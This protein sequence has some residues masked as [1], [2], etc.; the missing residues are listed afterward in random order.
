MKRLFIFLISLFPITLFA[1][2]TI[3]V[4][5]YNALNY[6]NFTSYCTTTNNSVSSKEG[7]FRS[8]F[9]YA[10]ADIIGINEISGAGSYYSKR[11]LD[12]VLNKI[13]PN[14]YEK[15]QYFNSTSSDLVNMLYFNKSKFA[16]KSQFS[17]MQST[18]DICFFK[19]YYLS[20]NLLQGDTVYLTCISMHLKAGSTTEDETDRA[21]ETNVLMNYI[22]NA[23]V[24]GNILVMG[25]FNVYGSNEE[26]FQNL[27]NNSVSSINFY[28]PINKLGSW[29]NNSSYASYHTQS[30]HLS[31]SDCPASGGLDDR[32]DFILINENIKYNT[33][34]VSYISSTYK[35]I[36]QDGN[37][38][39]QSVNSPNNTS[40]PSDVISALFNASDHLPV[41]MS[42][43]INTTPVSS[44]MYMI[45]KPDL[46]TLAQNHY[47]ISLK[48]ANTYSFQ[49]FNLN[50]IDL[51]IE[52][53]SNINENGIEIFMNHL[54]KG[55]YVLH[56]FDDKKVFTYKIVRL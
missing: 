51:P 29:N 26:G 48:N 15:G 25:D 17:L 11:F 39:N 14:K 8:I 19:L 41:I 42:L 45:D 32:F 55:L 30:T 38:F 46:Q 9:S 23:G 10:N 43:K 13:S 18:R 4:L 31:S 27:V 36:G 22:H 16:I 37:H 34:K 24:S 47:Y 21:A 54:P 28:D 52:N 56:L 20:P 53:F 50:G 33:S 5:T 40:A 2:D 3:K 35:A 44:S 49:I 6:G 12:S 1:Q 7:Y